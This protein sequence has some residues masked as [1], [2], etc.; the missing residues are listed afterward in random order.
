MQQTT[1]IYK[2]MV[3]SSAFFV[4]AL[5]VGFLTKIQDIRFWLKFAECLSDL[6]KLMT[7]SRPD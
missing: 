4:G 6:Q 1:L 7:L 3:L 2:Q 5:G